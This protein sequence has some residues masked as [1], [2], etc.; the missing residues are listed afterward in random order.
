[1][2]VLVT[3]GAGF[4][5]SHIVDALVEGGYE[6]CVVD[7]LSTGR[8]E[9]LKNTVKLYKI[10][11][12]DKAI[13]DVFEQEKFN[14]VIHE[15]A[16]VSVAR[17][18]CDIELDT[19]CNILG[20]INILE[21]SRLTGVKK[22]IFAGSAAIYGNPEYLPIDENHPRCP[23]SPYGISKYTVQH[24]LK[25]YRDS[26]GLDFTELVYS[27]VYG[28]RQDAKGEGG[29]VAVFVD[30]LVSGKAPKIYGDGEQTRD[31]IY[32]G[33]VARANLAAITKGS[34]EICNVSWGREI[35]INTLYSIAKAKAGVDVEPQYFPPRQGDIRRSCLSNKKIREVLE[36]EPV[37]GLEEGIDRTIQA[38]V[39]K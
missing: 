4:I 6:V 29:V 15:A 13:L 31:F 32:V 36:W 12:R 14:V 30:A 16:Q 39:D 17:S 28:P 9:N 25:F 10:D 2:K 8:L 3:G 5:G 23:I 37:V 34:G 24:Y 27:N 26:Y 20:T 38:R 11:I 35:P 18:L 7:D 21:S 1:M 33:D 19:T 22:V